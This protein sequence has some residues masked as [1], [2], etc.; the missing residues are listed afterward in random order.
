M[1]TKPLP[2]KGIS[3]V[4]HNLRVGKANF[5]CESDLIFLDGQPFV[6]LDWEGPPENQH[7]APTLPLDP[8]QLEPS[9]GDDRLFCV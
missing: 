6:V 9:Q 8:A 5:I 4:T 3:R 1:L 7:P 2:E